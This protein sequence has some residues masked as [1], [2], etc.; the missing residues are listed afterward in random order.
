MFLM[1]IGFIGIGCATIG[2]LC[3]I[4][5]V[6]GHG[7]M[8]KLR[9]LFFALVLGAIGT[10]GVGLAVVLHA[11]QAFVVDT[12]VAD[13]RTRWVGEKAFELTWSPVKH[14][15]WERPVVR[16]FQLKGDQWA[17]SGGIVKWSPWLTALGVPSYHKPTR[18]SGR[19][20]HTVEETR[21]SPTA[22]DVNGGMDPV[23]WWFY[24]LDPY[25]P[26]VQAVYGSTAYTFINPARV[27]E[28]SVTSSGY[29]ITTAPPPR[30]RSKPR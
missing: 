18:V 26:F 5:V 1:I 19:Y 24:T 9:Y 8:A 20:V 11:F 3:L 29:M 23:W 25:L 16:T 6:R 7:L 28:V 21:D 2:G 4:G 17:I 22:Y 15:I 30:S 12:P 10:L 14:E 27:A 13:V